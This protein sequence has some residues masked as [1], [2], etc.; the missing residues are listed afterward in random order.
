MN[1]GEWSSNGSIS[2]SEIGKK[3]AVRTVMNASWSHNDS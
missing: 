1:S 2:Y 3:R